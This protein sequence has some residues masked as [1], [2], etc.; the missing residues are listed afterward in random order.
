MWQQDTATRSENFR[1]TRLAAVAEVEAQGPLFAAIIEYV[2]WKLK[3][4]HEGFSRR[5]LY[6]QA[7]KGAAM[8]ETIVEAFESA[9]VRV[10]LD[11]EAEIVGTRSGSSS[12]IAQ[13][14]AA[15]EAVIEYEIA[16]PRSEI[17][18]GEP[19]IDI[20]G[21][22]P[23]EA[24][25]ELLVRARFVTGQDPADCDLRYYYRAH[26]QRAELAEFD[27][28]VAVFRCLERLTAVVEQGGAAARLVRRLV[29]AAVVDDIVATPVF[30]VKEV[31]KQ[32]KSG[33]EWGMELDEEE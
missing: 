1:S 5:Y 10:G 18:G 28:V 15:A 24:L 9:G 12:D 8:R 14:C 31:V 3:R 29:P 23:S 11:D 22:L 30:G 7:A 16:L 19:H 27:N 32:L 2:R 33:W 6:R 26:A 17:L 13:L 4:D 21:C 20:P 25:A